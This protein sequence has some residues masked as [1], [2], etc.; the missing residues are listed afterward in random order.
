MSLYLQIIILSDEYCCNVSSKRYKPEKTTKNYNMPHCYKPQGSRYE[1]W[2]LCIC[3]S[4]WIDNW[5]FT[6]N[7]VIKMY[8][9]MYYKNQYFSFL[10]EGDQSFL[11]IYSDI[12]CIA[13]RVSLAIFFTLSVSF[14][15]ETC[16]VHHQHS[17]ITYT[18]SGLH[19]MAWLFKWLV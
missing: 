3:Y 18:V 4:S 5:H 7:M 16:H 15:C 19:E 8:I 6:K 1:V 11:C 9:K 17:H 12:A 10:W 14:I 13:T 2:T